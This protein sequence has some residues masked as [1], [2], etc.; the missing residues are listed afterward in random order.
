MTEQKNPQQEPQQDEEK[1][2]TFPIVGIGASAGG[3]EA[4]QEFFDCMPTASGAAFVIVQHLSP[5]YKSFM[6]ELLSRH[7]SIAI[8]VASDGVAIESDH[9]YLIPPK[10]NMTIV[11]GKLYLKEI[12]GRH[13]NLPIDIFFRS[14]AA[15][16]ENNAIGI[17]LSGTGSDGTLGIRAIKETGG[18]TMAQDDQTAKFDGMPRSSISTGMI[19]FV[20][21]PPQMAQELANYIKHPFINKNSSIES[22]L[23][24]NQSVF[25]KI[26]AIL[27]DA[28]NVDFSNYKQNTLIRRLEKRISINRFEK[29]SDYVSFLAVTPKEVS[30]LFNDMLI[31]VTRFF[32]DEKSFE[33]LASAV[34]PEIFA[35]HTEKSEIRVW[36]PACSTGEEAYTLAIL[37]KDYMSANNIIKEVKIFATDID[38][39]SLSFA[40]EGFYPSNISAD[41]PSKILAKHFIRRDTDYQINDNIR[42]MIIFARHNIIDEPAFSKLDLI[43]C[44][45]LLIYLNID[46]QQKILSTFHLCLKNDGFMFLGSSESLGKLSEGFD[47]FDSKAKIFK[48]RNRYKPE[49][50]PISSLATPLHRNR[51]EML[52]TQSF[53][54]QLKLGSRQLEYVFEDIAHCYLPPSVIIDGQSN[55]LYS[56]HDVSKYLHLPKGQ[57][58]SNLLRM[59]PKDISVIVSSLIRRAEK[60]Q[61]EII[62]DDIETG[63]KD[64]KLSISCKRIENSDY[65]FSCYI[66]SFNEKEKTPSEK[67]GTNKVVSVN[68]NTQYQERIEELEREIQQKNE[69]LQATVEELETSNEELQSS[70]EE[71]IASN[72][73]L[74]STNE[75]L[76]SVNEELYTVNSEHIRKIEE[77]TELNSDYDN[78]LRNTFI[79][80][81]FLDRNLVIR[82]ISDVASSITNVLPSDVG[83]PIQHLSLKSLYREFLS[84]I[85]SVSETLDLVEKEIMHSNKW[86]FMRMLPYRTTENA[87]DGIII[88]F[89]DITRLKESQTR[90]NEMLGRAQMALK[91]GKM[92][93]WEWDITSNV[94]SVGDN[95]QSLIGMESSEIVDV[96]Y[97]NTLVHPDDAKLRKDALD[98]HISGKNPFYTVEY[99]IKHKDG[100]FIWVK[101]MGQIVSCEKD[102]SPEKM[103]GIISDITIEKTQK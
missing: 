51:S 82:K 77:L 54:N 21:P 15:D 27:H 16:Q 66:V 97:W 101:D 41:V 86:Y 37:F 85:E 31:G 13:L 99:R 18:M 19:D 90:V 11:G 74:Q 33:L 25:N 34:I 93:W 98:M 20:L 2:R 47:I 52:Q 92:T 88:T 12:I 91:A 89:V 58:T 76:Q 94:I 26:I 50:L 28:K 35:Q 4:L 79:G 40:G 32:R 95:V 83:R 72:E 65:D 29:I 78:L 73:E 96:E 36:V 42:R 102:G 103:S 1:P 60:K 43:S 63:E 75:E 39:E 61:D 48:K 6:G 56:I 55:V 5:D 67:I 9:I 49:V 71:L 38:E 80:N 100:H 14:L 46:V 22:Q 10:M 53:T 17:I 69:S 8:E 45:N 44:R 3:L 7:T 81:L 23:L 70:N 62:Y 57:I 87:V 24:Q 59:L 68:I 30:A 64:K 84:D